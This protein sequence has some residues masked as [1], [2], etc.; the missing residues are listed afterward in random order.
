MLKNNSTIIDHIWC[1]LSHQTHSSIVTVDTVIK[2]VNCKTN[3]IIDFKF[4]DYS[5][6]NIEAFKTK[7]RNTDWSLLICNT[8][9]TDKAVSVFLDKFNLFHDECFPL[10]KKRIGV[11]RLNSPWINNTL[12]KSIRLKH[13]KFKQSKLGLLEYETAKLYSKLLQKVLREAKRNFY[14]NAFNAAKDDI[15]KSWKLINGQ[16]NPSKVKRDIK[17]KINQTEIPEN[18]IPDKFN[19]KFVNVASELRDTI[20][21]VTESYDDFLSTSVEN[22]MFLRP[23]CTEE[24]IKIISNIKNTKFNVNKPSSRIYKFVKH[25]IAKPISLL[26]NKII[27]NGHYPKRLKIARITPIFKAGDKDN[28]NNYRPISNL[29]TLNTIFEKLLSKRLNDF[30]NFNNVLNECQFGFRK[31]RST[32]DAVSKLLHEAYLAINSYKYCGVISLDLSK[33]FDTVDHRILLAKLYNYGLR[34]KVFDL[35]TSYLEDRSQFV[36]VNGI[37]STMKPITSGVP[38]GSVLG[39]LLFLL[40]VNDMPGTLVKSSMIMYADDTTIFYTHSDINNL[41]T[42]LNNELKIV[43]GWLKANFSKYV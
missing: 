34:G 12:I 43:N 24:V 6:K 11:K 32:G 9:D 4:R 5:A 27:E 23:S 41:I 14:E 35:M 2:N 13:F 33:A 38:Q 8:T 30:L 16:I 17:I 25:E 36:S 3:K 18:E 40:Y 15:K 22:S 26:F 20:P 42:V 10:M 37:S 29:E 31:G 7:L 28:I 19:D 1:N 39:P 21:D